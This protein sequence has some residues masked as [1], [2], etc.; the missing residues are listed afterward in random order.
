MIPTY[1]VDSLLCSSRVRVVK[2]HTVS[3]NLFYVYRILFRLFDT[4]LTGKLLCPMAPGH[5]ELLGRLAPK[6]SAIIYRR[7]VY[8]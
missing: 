7:A 4:A 3:S 1:V 5:G 8:S 2:I 6:P